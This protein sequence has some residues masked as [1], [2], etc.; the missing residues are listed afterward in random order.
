MLE[1]FIKQTIGKPFKLNPTKLLRNTN[2]GD[3]KDKIK[4]NKGFFCSELVATG[5]KRLGLLDPTI[6]ASKYWPGDFSSEQQMK[7]LKGAKL[8]E[9]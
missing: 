9:E 7:L 1:D 8:G 3:R 2:E 4:E 6:A 5:Y